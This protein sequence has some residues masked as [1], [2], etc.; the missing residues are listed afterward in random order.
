M[1]KTPFLS[2]LLLWPTQALAI[3]SYRFLHVTIDTAWIIFVFLFFL[4]F[5][6]MILMAV[7][8]WKYAFSDQD[9]ENTKKKKK[10]HKQ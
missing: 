2:L 4:V 1:K 3:D 9:D 5:T 7:L 8:Y 6:P 10:D